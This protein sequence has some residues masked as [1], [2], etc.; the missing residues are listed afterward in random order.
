MLQVQIIGNL[1][2]DAEVKEINGK[3]YSAF[4]VAA[5]SRNETTWVSILYSYRENLH[6]YLIK[7]QQVFVQG[8][9]RVK[10]YTSKNSEKTSLDFSVLADKL[11]LC[12]SKADKAV[13]QS[14]IQAQRMPPQAQPQQT[15]KDDLPFS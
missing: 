5:T 14:P 12:G 8:E 3:Q 10:L 15:F 13:E 1:G 6:K 9:G 7:G 2:A 4:R 11:Q